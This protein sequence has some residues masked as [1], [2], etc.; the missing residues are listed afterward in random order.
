MSE[1]IYSSH[2][3]SFDDAKG[4]CIAHIKVYERHGAIWLSD[5]WVHAEHRRQGRATRLMRAA[6]ARYGCETIYLEAS[7]YTDQAV[8]LGTLTAW[9]GR[10]G[11]VATD[12]PNVMV[13]PATDLREP[14]AALAHE[15]W[16]GWMQYM[17]AKCQIND[18]GSVTIP[19]K[20][21]Q[22]LFRQMT[23]PYA[24]L[25]ELEKDGDR[26]EAER[27]LILLNAELFGR[28]NPMTEAAPKD[29]S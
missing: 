11:F 5:L 21:H 19:A 1:R 13:R 18:D 26:A 23:T 28:G 10:F 12:V 6:L 20:Y 27:V 29:L 17:L 4:E 2:R 3:Y 9:Y 7:P 14:L 8:D 15:Q 25:S 24:E 22:A 16:S